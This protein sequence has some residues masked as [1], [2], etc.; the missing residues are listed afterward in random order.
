MDEN[1]RKYRKLLYR[2]IFNKNLFTTS[3][4]IAITDGRCGYTCSQFLKHLKEITLEKVVIFGKDVLTKSPMDFS[5]FAGDSVLKSTDV[6]K[7]TFEDPSL[8][9]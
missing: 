1:L 9:F 7:L 5:S 6:Q 8:P 2:S 4:I 3:D